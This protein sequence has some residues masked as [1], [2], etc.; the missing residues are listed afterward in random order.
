MFPKIVYPD[1]LSFES[2]II[3]LSES[4]V[5]NLSLNVSPDG[6]NTKKI[7]W[8]V[9]DENIIS[10]ENGTVTALSPGA[11]RVT[12]YFNENVFAE[13]NVWVRDEQMGYPFVVSSADVWVYEDI[14]DEEVEFYINFNTDSGYRV[15]SVADMDIEIENKYGVN[16]YS[17]TLHV[18]LDSF[19]DNV[20]WIAFP[21]NDI[22]WGAIEDGTLRYRI[23][24]D[25]YFDLGWKEN[26]MISL[27]TYYEMYEGA[28]VKKAEIVDGCYNME[29]L[30][31]GSCDKREI[32]WISVIAG[33]LPVEKGKMDIE[34][35][36]NIGSIIIEDGEIT[37]LNK[38]DNWGKYDG[39][40]LFYE[41]SADLSKYNN[42][43]TLN[44]E[45][46]LKKFVIE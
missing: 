23:Y 4:E 27:P 1:K 30:F 43:V 5:Y 34:S 7:Q 3:G 40:A 10:V 42:F 25:E 46:N 39:I 12:A 9:E 14:I 11:T 26:T 38:P 33:S 21:E 20:A 36:G 8:L 19:D 41:Y 44:S 29:F 37:K 35:D 16:V 13:C 32:F 22:E 45:L 18:D 17:K 6:A 24:N 28:I 15:S 31:D 2:T